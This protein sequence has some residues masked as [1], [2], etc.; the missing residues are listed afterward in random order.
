M[1]KHYK[2]RT[3]SLTVNS[4]EDRETEDID[5]VSDQTP[6]EEVIRKERIK[7]VR[8]AVCKLPEEQR[9][10]IVLREFEN[11]QYSEI[12]VMLGISEGTVKSRISRG[13]EALKKVLEIYK[14]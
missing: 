1:R 4:G 6:D 3:L 9:D 5:I 13:R 2:H 14:L 12:A 10:V 7:A 11:L 8:E